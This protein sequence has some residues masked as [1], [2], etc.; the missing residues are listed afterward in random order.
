MKNE[1]KC[2]NHRASDEN[3]TRGCASAGGHAVS[4]GMFWKTGKHQPTHIFKIFTAVIKSCSQATT[5]RSKPMLLT[6]GNRPFWIS[7]DR[8]FSLRGR[9]SRS[10]GV[11]LL[12]PAAVQAFF[13]AGDLLLQPG[14]GLSRLFNAP[15]RIAGD[16]SSSMSLV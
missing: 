7:A 6:L 10:A 2:K 1:S 9:L 14:M 13:C 3:A 4:I 8:M 12:F 15:S 16:R 11:N 5:E